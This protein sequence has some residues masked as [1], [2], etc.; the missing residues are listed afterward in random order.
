[1]A[2]KKS[3]RK[4]KIRKNRATYSTSVKIVSESNEYFCNNIS[5]PKNISLI[6]FCSKILEFTDSNT[7]LCNT[8]DYFFAKAILCWES[9]D[10]DSH[11]KAL[12][13]LLSVI[14]QPIPNYIEDIINKEHSFILS[15]RTNFLMGDSDFKVMVHPYFLLINLL[16]TEGMAITKGKAS[17]Y[18]NCLL[19][20]LSKFEKLS[21]KE[22]KIF[23]TDT[24]ILYFY[25]YFHRLLLDKSEDTLKKVT[26]FLNEYL[27]ENKSQ[28]IYFFLSYFNL[29]K[30]DEVAL[31]YARKFLDLPNLSEG[32]SSYKRAIAF[33]A[34]MAAIRCS[35]WDDYYYWVEIY[36]SIV[37]ANN[38]K[39]ISIKE[40]ADEA[41]EI[42]LER[43][44]HP[45]NPKNV[46]PVTLESVST[47]N[48]IVLI[49]LLE[50]CGKEWGLQ[51]TD[52]K[53]RYFFPSSIISRELIK[54][55]LQGHVVKIS[56]SDFNALTTEDLY[57]F[58]SI[59]DNCKVH[60]N[61]I[62]I[63]DTK[64]I[65]CSLLREEVLRRED[66]NESILALWH[67]LVIGYFY[68]TMEYYLSEN[69]E[70]W[71]QDFSLNESTKER[72][73]NITASAKRLSYAAFTSIRNTAGADQLNKTTGV[74]HTQNLL[75]HYINRNLDFI[76]ESSPDY[77]KTRYEKAPIYSI[78]K[79]IEEFCGVD[80]D[81]IY[82]EI[83][84]FQ[85]INIRTQL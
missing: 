57:N 16:M 44:H 17:T 65:S 77:S 60:L 18:F 23:I 80:P 78:E 25:E 83:P 48:L 27:T 15:E 32:V 59:I 20:I 45:I 55:L 24:V 53:L 26:F 50:S 4:G 70:P 7:E 73:K 49:A 67:I 46:V 22:P 34:S 56:S 13:S 10:Y 74:R 82:D 29:N 30:N 31:E 54:L 51:I 35:N 62:G 81:T 14:D 37:G 68:N 28:T 72:I 52:Q 11:R 79:I 58:D 84:S 61:I 19:D 42:E 64:A 12:I 5:L 3:K 41:I 39:L 36:E 2:N 76:E 8:P 63:I 66:L 85:F 71:A 43:A 69:Y 38:E 47:Q 21:E 6:D 9:K 40:R 33:N 75:I 1:M